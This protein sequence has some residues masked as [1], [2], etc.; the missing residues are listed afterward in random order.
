[1]MAGAAAAAAARRGLLLAAALGRLGVAL[2]GLGAVLRRLRPRAGRGVA[3]F[4]LR[5]ALEVGGVPAAAL[6]LEARRRHH[7]GEGGL[8]ATGAH[9]D[10]RVAHFLQ[11]FLLVAAIGA[12]V[13]VDGHRVPCLRDRI[14]IF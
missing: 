11:E 10:R 4:G 7:L 8:A 9:R 13:L 2:G 14:F 3:G 6:Q 5:A 1:S 12:P